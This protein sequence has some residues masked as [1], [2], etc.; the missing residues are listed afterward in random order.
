MIINVH[1]HAQQIIDFVNSKNS[2]GINIEFSQE[3]EL[4]DTGGG[5]KKASWF[6]DDN[7]PF[8]LHN[9]DVISDMNIAE[10][11]EYH[12]IISCNNFNRCPRT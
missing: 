6:F 11:L 9:V 4:L 2:F 8:L 12:E 5:L 7:E 1:H 10:M 3:N